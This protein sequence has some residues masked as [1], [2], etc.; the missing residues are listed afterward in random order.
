[1]N[2]R[3]TKYTYSILYPSSKKVTRFSEK[4]V[5]PENEVL[6]SPDMS[7]TFHRLPVSTSSGTKH[8]RA[9]FTQLSLFNIAGPCCCASKKLKV[10]TQ[11]L[12]NDV[13]LISAPNNGQY[14]QNIITA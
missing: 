3:A 2:S 8:E 11:S 9:R 14:S 10:Q 4:S 5:F 6:S 7:S 13:S 1:M 12:Q